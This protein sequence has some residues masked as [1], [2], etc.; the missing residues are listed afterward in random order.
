LFVITYT[1][2]Q[3]T[4]NIAT[5]LVKILSIMTHSNTQQHITRERMNCLD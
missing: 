1:S 5:R 3:Y 2:N 4:S